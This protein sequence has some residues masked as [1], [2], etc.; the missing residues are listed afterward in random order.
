MALTS[1]SD[2]R[3]VRRRAV[4][5]PLRRFG[6]KVTISALMP[7]LLRSLLAT[8]FHEASGRRRDIF[9]S[10]AAPVTE[11]LTTKALA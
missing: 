10:T 1:A 8:S 11:Q 5:H 4:R 9:A 3:G 2:P 6:L 7:H